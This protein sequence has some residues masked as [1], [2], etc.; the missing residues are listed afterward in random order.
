MESN[1]GWSQTLSKARTRLTFPR[2]R[3]VQPPVQPGIKPVPPPPAPQQGEGPPGQGAPGPGKDW[4]WRK[5]AFH[6]K[7]T[8]SLVLHTL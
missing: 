7:T 2:G 5:M 3:V 6:P 4:E 8:I 1:E